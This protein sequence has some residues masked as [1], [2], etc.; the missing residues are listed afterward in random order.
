MRRWISYV[1]VVMGSL[2]ATA[3]QAAEFSQPA[4]LIREPL[5]LSVVLP[6][7]KRQPLMPSSPDRTYLVA[8]H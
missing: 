5:V 1:F 4:G 6:D 8:N 2:V 3:L 7:G